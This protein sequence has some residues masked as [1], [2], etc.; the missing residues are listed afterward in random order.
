VTQSPTSQPARIVYRAPEHSPSGMVVEEATPAEAW[1][2]TAA[3]FAVPPGATTELDQHDVVELWMVRAGTGTI[4]SGD[5]TMDVAPGSMVF[6][7]S[8]VPH[9]IT[10]TGPDQLELFSAWWTGSGA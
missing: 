3:R 10:N 2:F 7:P 6:F 1:P 4:A 8:R 9:R 5:S